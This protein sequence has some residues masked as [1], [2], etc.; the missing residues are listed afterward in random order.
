MR[1]VPAD[2][3]LPRQST[4][5]E[6][7]HVIISLSGAIDIASAPA[8]REQLLGLLR[9]AASQLIMDLSAVSYADASGLAVLVG[10]ARRARLLGGFLRLAAPSPAVTEAL[11]LTGVDRCIDVFQTVQ[12]AMTDLDGGQG[13]PASGLG[14]AAGSGMTAAAA[15][16]AALVMQPWHPAAA[17]EL[18]IAVAAVLHHADAWRDADP[19]RQFTS[20]LQTL[21]T[22]YSGTSHAAMTQAARVLLLTLA[23]RP[24]THSAAVAT[25]ASH[26]RGLL[27]PLPRPAIT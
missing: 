24:L 13:R 7:A 27:L 26:L 19:H 6:R 22:A 11:H 8:L 12:A 2:E 14:S 10:T 1:T 18:R 25:S 3:V 23:R 16:A 17:D 9:R 4:R 5:M 20:A 15:P 21:A